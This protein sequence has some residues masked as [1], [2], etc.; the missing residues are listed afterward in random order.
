MT[1]CYHFFKTGFSIIQIAVLED[2]K[3]ICRRSSP[4]RLS[5]TVIK[6]NS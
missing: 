6:K 4:S 5:S 2:Y 1:D 3:N